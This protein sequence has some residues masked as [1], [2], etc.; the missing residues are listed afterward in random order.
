VEQML[1]R[2]GF[3][4]YTLPALPFSKS[5]AIAGI[6]CVA[7]LVTPYSFRLFPEIIKTVYSK[8]QFEAFAEMSSMEFRRPQNFV[9]LLLVMAAFFALG[10]QRS[11]DLFKIAVMNIFVI[12]AFRI[13]RDA[14]CVV[15]P[16]IAVLADALPPFQHEAGLP[17][18]ARSWKWE[19]PLVAVLVLVSLSVAILR[20]PKDEQLIK[21]ASRT[22]PV[23]ACDYIRENQL[24]EPLFNS[25]AW[26][27]FLT[28]YLP[29]YPVAIDGRSNLYGNEIDEMYFKV[30]GGSVRLEDDPSFASARTIL[31]ERNAGMTKALTTLPQLRQQ[32]RVAYEDDLAVV[33]ARISQGE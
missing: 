5:L 22:F 2:S 20:L 21:S 32:F 3:G 1:H 12:L 15:L 28:W 30:T 23:K 11:R 29:Q 18:N 8:V 10:R 6:T 24:P 4:S 16:A 26:G 9:L 17:K 33:L 25:Y 31:L 13:Q 27:G 7:T 19:M 14:W